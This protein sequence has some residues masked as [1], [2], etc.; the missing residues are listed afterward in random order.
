MFEAVILAAGFSSRVGS[1]KM[2][3]LIDNK[4][5]LGN[6]I[7]AFSSLC[8]RIIVVGGHYYNE[9]ELITSQYESVELVKNENYSK[10]M[11]SSILH[12]VSFV[13]ENCFICPGD[14]PLINTSVVEKLSV[15]IGEFVVPTYNGKRGHPVLLN[16]E[17]IKRLKSE[18]VNSNLKIFRDSCKI[19]EVEVMEEGILLDIDT[20][21]DYKK[22]RNI[23][24]GVKAVETT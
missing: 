13:N 6:T 7:E 1:N 16:A 24:E 2:E 8:Q 11:F 21:D 15:E 17:T 5:V 23:K 9:V 20:I 22:I 19:T 3:L 14:Y 18:P 4:P 10:G 12:G